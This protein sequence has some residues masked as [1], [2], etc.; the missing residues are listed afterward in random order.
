MS[1]ISKL[2]E[3]ESLV[4]NLLNDYILKE[5]GTVT[6]GAFNGSLEVNNGEEKNYTFYLFTKNDE[7][8]GEITFTLNANKWRLSYRTI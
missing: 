6:N 3:I 4:R 7:N 1:Y 2:N 5:S 8:D